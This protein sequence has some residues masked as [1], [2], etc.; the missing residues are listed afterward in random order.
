MRKL[1]SSIGLILLST[2][3]SLLLGEWLLRIVLAPGDFLQ[4]NLVDDP[5]LG[6]RIEPNAIGHDALGFR[7]SRVPQQVDVVAVGDS[8][9]YGVSAT[10]EGSWPQQ[11]AGLL[12]KPVYS[13]ALGGYGPMDYLYLIQHETPKLHPK[14]LVVGFYFGNDLMDACWAVEQRAVWISWRSGTADMC[15]RDKHAPTQAESKKRFGALRDWMTSH[16][17]LYG[18]LKATILQ[19]LVSWEKEDAARQASADAQ[20]SWTDPA[21]ASVRTIFTTLRPPNSV[22]SAFI[23]SV[24]AAFTSGVK[25]K[26]SL[27]G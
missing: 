18:V 22:G 8:Q 15:K 20:M 7:N 19:R 10:R 1:A 5:V 9:T 13:M 12:G 16:S 23:F 24:N 3:L 4:V 25:R 21:D 2:V 11:L 6:H 17:V 27:T 26:F 14:Q